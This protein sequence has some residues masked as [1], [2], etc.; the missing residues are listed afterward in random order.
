MKKIFT[1]GHSTHPIEEFLSMLESFEIKTLV[2]VRRLPGSRK[3][4]QFD[5]ENL[6]LSLAAAGLNYLYFADLGGRRKAKKDSRNTRW[7][8]VSFKGYADYMETEQ[9][10]QALV[11]LGNTALASTTVYMCAEALW[12]RCHRSMISDDLKAKG[13]NVFHIMGIGKAQG[14]TFTKPALVTGDKV[15]YAEEN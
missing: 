12:W 9:F 8:N 15:S 2:D 11:E 10:E 5:Q 1:I 3:Y 7:N 4:P 6:R 13:W 14:H